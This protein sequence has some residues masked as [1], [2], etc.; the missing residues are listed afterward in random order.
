MSFQG[1]C[2]TLDDWTQAAATCLATP[3]L[4]K[5]SRVSLT[6]PSREAVRA[7]FPHSSR[8]RKS[9]GEMFS[10]PTAESPSQC[11][12]LVTLSS[13]LNGK[14]LSQRR[15][16]H[17]GAC[18][19]I[20]VQSPNGTDGRVQNKTPNPTQCFHLSVQRVA[21]LADMLAAQRKDSL[22]GVS[23]RAAARTETEWD[24][25][26]PACFTAW[27]IRSALR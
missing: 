19:R 13:P 14:V 9:P 23:D 27:F 22:L 6:S 17:G 1:L 25:S 7:W 2:C 18:R 12:Y 21:L 8:M 20:P 15:R 16:P 26:L 24:E 11:R 5:T 10:F 3:L 4:F